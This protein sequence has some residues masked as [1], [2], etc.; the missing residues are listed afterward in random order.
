M[1]HPVVSCSQLVR[2]RQACEAGKERVAQLVSLTVVQQ[3]Q[4]AFISWLCGAM[5]SRYV[6]TILGLSNWFRIHFPVDRYAGE[7]GVC[8]SS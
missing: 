4:W 8:L 2:K 6:T 7:Q 1:F 3:M 5:R